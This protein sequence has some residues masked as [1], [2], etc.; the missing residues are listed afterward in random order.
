MQYKPVVYSNSVQ[1]MLAIIRAMGTL[2]IDFEDPTRQV[3]L[4]TF[5]PTMIS[6]SYGKLIKEILGSYGKFWEVTVSFGKLRELT[7]SYG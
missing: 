3:T 2:G 7:V 4:R 6:E 1:S 5:N